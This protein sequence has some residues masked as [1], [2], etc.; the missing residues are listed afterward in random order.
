MDSVG[1]TYSVGHLIPSYSIHY[2]LGYFSMITSTFQVNTLCFSPMKVDLGFG[3]C[4]V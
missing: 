4:R 1:F 2:T 3:V